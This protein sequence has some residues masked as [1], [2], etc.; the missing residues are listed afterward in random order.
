MFSFVMYV[1][2][3]K[4]ARICRSTG[5]TKGAS[6]EQTSVRWIPVPEF[7][8]LFFIFFVALGRQS[9]NNDSQQGNAIGMEEMQR[10]WQEKAR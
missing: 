8:F 6:T 7:L 4:R 10:L 3:G 5:K 1:G 9:M 2:V